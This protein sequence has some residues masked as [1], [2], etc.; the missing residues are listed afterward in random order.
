M[1]STR[2]YRFFNRGPSAVVRLAFFSALSLIL[3]FVD[4]RFKTFEGVRA[5][6]QI[7]VYPFQRLTYL[8]GSVWDSVGG[9]FILQRNLLAE[10]A[11]LAQQHNLDSAKLQQ[12][13]VLQT[14]NQQLRNLFEM[15]QRADYPVQITEVAYVESDLF[16]RKVIIDKGSLGKVKAGQIVMD[17]KGIVGQVTRVYPFTSEVTLIT[18]KDHA[19]PVQVLRNGLRAVVFGA[20]NISELTLRYMPVSSDILVGD[21]LVTSGIDGTYPAGISVAKITQIE[22]DPA[23][24]FA[25]IV[26]MPTAGVDKSRYLLIADDLSTLPERPAVEDSTEKSGAKARRGASR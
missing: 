17:D 3:L 18:D 21:E 8:P 23:Y 9:Y 7:V 2:S 14:E 25:R 12:L 15:R 1:E 24:P 4:A 11:Q 13:H 22:R 20:G 19:V 6:L 5:A 16:K 26:C 10:N